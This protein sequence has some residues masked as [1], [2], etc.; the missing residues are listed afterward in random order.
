MKDTDKIK[1]QISYENHTKWVHQEKK[2]T[3]SCI[4]ESI[5]GLFQIKRHSHAV[6]YL[7]LLQEHLEVGSGLGTRLASKLKLILV[8]SPT[9]IV[10]H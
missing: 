1:E 5:P 10:T 8:I 6:A 2:F 7:A 3:T 4:I 9:S